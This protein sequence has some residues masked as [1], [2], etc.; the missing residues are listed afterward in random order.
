[1][2]TRAKVELFEEIRKASSRRDNPSIRE[3]SRRFGVHRRM[4]RQALESAI[5]P[6]RKVAPRKAPSLGPW[7]AT[8]DTWLAEDENVPKKQRHA[9]RRIFRG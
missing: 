9:A 2:A 4:V 7:K 3:L 6:P 8:I 1:M 5:P